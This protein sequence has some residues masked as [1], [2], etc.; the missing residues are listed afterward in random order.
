MT[1]LTIE[2]FSCIKSA[3]FE[4][5]PVTVMIGPQGSGKSVT[6]KLLYFCLDTFQRQYSCAEKGVSIEEFKKETVKQFKVWFPVSAWGENRFNIN[7]VAGPFTVR[8]L[9]RMSKGCPVDDLTVTFG[10]FFHEEY[11]LLT[12]EYERAKSE[13]FEDTGNILRRSAQEIWRVREQSEERLTAALGKEHI[14]SQTFI[15]AGR[16][17]FTSI[18]R[19]VA[20]IEQ[21]SSLDPVTIRF[22]KLFAAIRDIANRGHIYNRRPREQ[23]AA[24]GRV[25]SDLF[26]G[27]IK[28]ERDQEFVET[29][30]GRSI[31]FT[32]LS[33]G[34]QELLPMW[35]LVDFYSDREMRSDAG[36]LLYIEEPEAHLFP[37]AQS[38]LM[39]FLIGN[40]VSKKDNRN[41]I[42][43]THSPYILAKLNNYLLAGQVGSNLKKSPKVSK[44]V[45]KELWLI[46]SRVK[47]YAFSK[48]VL[49]DI[50]DGDGLIDAEYIDSVSAEV[51]ETFT[52]L[53]DI[54]FSS[55]K[56]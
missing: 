8:F 7:F 14:Q 4:L 21:G 11:S 9:R 3:K 24:R 51:S 27:E 5:A 35:L 45:S 25:M 44:V 20:A 1:T 30:D 12:A 28:F 50:M 13:S 26:G 39:D 47:A 41:L 6:S 37:E 34:Q 55:E 43:T 33:S 54:Q 56:M 17:F 16:A 53:L 46:P 29:K 52:E 31:P 15:P 38:V 42:L 18:G 19:L 40:L 2:D 22:A 10:E 36:E 32:A 48:G 23:S 49:T